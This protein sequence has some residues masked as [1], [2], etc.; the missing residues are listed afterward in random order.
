MQLERF[1]KLVSLSKTSRC[2]GTDIYH[3]DIYLLFWHF[4]KTGGSMKMTGNNPIIKAMA[5][6]ISGIVQFWFPC[7]ITFLVN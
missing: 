3:I 7:S 1:S 6:A 5:N 2:K 4:K